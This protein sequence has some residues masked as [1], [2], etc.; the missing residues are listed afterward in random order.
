MRELWIICASADIDIETGDPSK[1]VAIASVF[2]V[3]DGKLV[4]LQPSNDDEGN[5]RYDMRVIAH[6]VEYA[7]LARDCSKLVSAT[8]N[9]PNSS[10]NADLSWA[11]DHSSQN[12]SDSLWL[13][14]GSDVKAW[15]DVQTLLETASTEF[16]RDVTP[17]IAMSI[18]FYPL[19]ILVQKGLVFGIEPELTQGRDANFSAFRISP[20]VGQTATVWKTDTNCVDIALYSKRFPIP[21]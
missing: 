12:L 3:V 13:F 6:D 14:D 1:D 7:L 8:S 2:F 15:T 18:D 4:L 11:E 19:S 17:S 10:E 21:S 20:R 16:A 9:F 5:L